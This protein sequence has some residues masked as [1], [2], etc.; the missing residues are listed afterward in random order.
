MTVATPHFYVE[1]TVMIGTVEIQCYLSMVT[2][3]P[4]VTFGDVE[5]YCTPGAEAVSKVAW[6]GIMRARM[7]YGNDASW[8]FFSTLDA[9]QTYDVTIYPADP[10]TT[11]GTADIP[12][13]NFDAYIAPIAFIPDHEIG[14]SA[15]YDI[16]FRVSGVPVFA[17]T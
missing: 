2:L 13:A 8:N 10:G 6:S 7:S 15:T 17:T 4:N 11:T 9:T 1:P 14:A 12:E 16:E 5:T 3:V